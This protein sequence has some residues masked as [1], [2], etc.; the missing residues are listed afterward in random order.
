ML[1]N[2]L[3]KIF[4]GSSRMIE[5]I[6]PVLNNSL[7][8]GFLNWLNGT[9]LGK[10][11]KNNNVFH[12]ICVSRPVWGKFSVSEKFYWNYSIYSKSFY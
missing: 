11:L 10:E 6:D 9:S 5:F 1:I 8:G 3:G 12:V 7:I 2:G 4:S